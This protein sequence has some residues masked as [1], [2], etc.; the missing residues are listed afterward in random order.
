[1]G[2]V[3]ERTS[4]V[5]L[6]DTLYYTL[7]YALYYT[8]Y[9]TV[10]YTLYYSV[11]WGPGFWKLPLYIGLRAHLT[12]CRTGAQGKICIDNAFTTIL[13]QIEYDL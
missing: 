9:Y 4:L 11:Y 12:R 5:W 7:Y 2:P 10:Y 13:E 8:L 1:M 3:L 6:Y